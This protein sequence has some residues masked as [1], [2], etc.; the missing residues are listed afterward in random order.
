[1]AEHYIRNVEMWVRFPP[2]ASVKISQKFMKDLI[3]LAGVPGSGK[4]TI[5][6]LLREKYGFV[7]IDFGWLRGGHLDNN[8]SNATSEEEGMAFEN[9]LFIIKNYWVHGYK[10]IIVTDLREDKVVT[11]AETFKD[12]NYI[13]VSLLI[14]DDKE[15]KKRVLGERDSGFKNVEEATRWNKAVKSKLTLANEYKI[16]NTHNDPEKTVK[17]I[18]ELVEK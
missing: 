6:E 12:K 4:S 10:N 7:L 3:I 8:W 11:L 9:L 13:I 5:G 2:S 14:A 1:M 17:E 18:S 16:D 15:L